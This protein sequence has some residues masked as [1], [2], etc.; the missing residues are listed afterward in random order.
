MRAVGILALALLASPALAQEGMY[1]G[2][3]LGSFDFKEDGAFLAPGPFDGTASSWK[4]Y[5]GFEFNDHF[6]MEIRYGATDRIEQ[7]FSG[8][9]SSLG[10]FSSTFS[11]DFK[12]TSIVAMGVLP[13][14]WGALIGGIGY[15]TA[16][17]GADLALTAEC[18][19]AISASTSVDDDGLMALLGVEWRF[20]RFG[21]GV[22]IRLEYEWMDVTGAGA[23][24]L[25][26]GVSYRF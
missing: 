2:L 5:G 12:T 22:G 7:P 3:A 1:V 24:T 18:C 26:V 17:Q 6:G 19:G 21:T 16:D 13:K 14:D 4:L 20:G 8:T 23:S 10:D 11:T 25:G 9:D 15:F